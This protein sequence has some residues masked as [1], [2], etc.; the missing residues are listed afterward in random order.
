MSNTLL[1][2]MDG[3]LLG[4]IVRRTA[5]SKERLS[6]SYDPIWLTRGPGVALSASMPLSEAPYDGDV[7]SNWLWGLLSDNERT[8]EGWSRHY[9]VGLGTPFGLLTHMGSDC[10]GA[11]QFVP[12]GASEGLQSGQT[13]P[14][15]EQ[16]IGEELRRI[17]ADP[18]ATGRLE[19]GRFS[20]AGAQSKIALR[21]TQDGWAVPNGY[22]PTSHIIKPADE[23][24]PGHAENEHFCLQLGLALGLNCAKSAIHHFDGQ[25]AIVVERFDRKW[26]DGRLHRVHQEDFCQALGLHPARKYESDGGPGPGD[27]A[28]VIANACS[29]RERDMKRFFAAVLFNFIIGGTDAHAKNYGLIYGRQNAGALAP[30]YDIASWLPYAG[31]EMRKLRFAMRMAGHYKDLA[32]HQ[33]HVIAAAKTT[34]V[35][36]AWAVDTLRYLCARAPDAASDVAMSCKKAGITHTVVDQLVDCIVERSEHLQGKFSLGG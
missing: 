30:L 21:K 4:R 15:N 33:R 23:G 9:Q 35:D 26:S 16:Q 36:Q 32:I 18:G 24:I 6:F 17:L 12:E 29:R 25:P 7:V 20:L 3:V 13:S 11:V 8:L 31:G 5:R 14:V 28:E 27:I 19:V 1:A 10:A 22:E 2:Y 34:G